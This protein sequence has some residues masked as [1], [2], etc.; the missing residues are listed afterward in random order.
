VKALAEMHH[1]AISTSSRWIK[2]A[3][4]RGYIKESDNG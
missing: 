3:R 4:R 2:E 1:A